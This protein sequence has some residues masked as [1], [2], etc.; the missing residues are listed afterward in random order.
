MKTSTRAA[1][2]AGLLALAACGGGGG[3]GGSTNP[4]ALL[5][6]SYVYV[7]LDRDTA[8]NGV[9]S[10]I[11]TL[12]ADG[13]GTII[14]GNAWQ[15][16]ENEPGVSLRR[17]NAPYQIGTDRSLAIAGAFPS[18]LTGRV[19]SGG[20]YAA[21]TAQDEEEDPGFFCAVRRNA[22]PTLGDLVGTWRV[23]QWMRVTADP[24]VAQSLTAVWT[25]D[26]AANVAVSDIHFNRNG[27]I[28]PF[29]ILLTPMLLMVGGDGALSVT[30]SG[31]TQWEGGMS[32]S[33]DV[34]L[35]GNPVGST[36]MASVLVLLK[37][38][39]LSGTAA[40]Q[41]SWACLGWEAW[42]PGYACLRGT[43]TF[44]AT[45]DGTWFA[46]PNHDTLVGM[47]V[48]S[49]IDS[50]VGAAGDVQVFWPFY[51]SVAGCAV[52][53]MMAFGGGYVAGREPCLWVLVR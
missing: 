1:L 51:N 30:S 24:H 37:E 41:G 48:T 50:D 3:G 29:S 22:S 44:D 47:G 27:V 9:Y 8:G 53:G 31:G 7:Y 38:G 45:A 19:S 40:L 23:V 52:P 43:A 33:G 10:E 39:R 35:L 42:M 18:R 12:T 28:D 2:L 6:G 46:D 32:A 49:A 14:F 34:I 16:G 26:G 25:V 11:A 20:S 17:A 21:A 13:V 15:T 36:R 4:A 5:S